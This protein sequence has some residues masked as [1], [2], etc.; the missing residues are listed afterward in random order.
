MTEG[1]ENGEHDAML[2]AIAAG[3]LDALERLYR[4]LRIGVFAAAVAVVRDRALAEDVLQDTFVRVLEKAS[5]Y[6]PGTRARAW[7][8]AIAR[9]LAIDA[10]RRRREP[11]R[12]EPPVESWGDPLGGL[13]VTRALLALE[14]VEREIVAL[15]A[16]GGLTHAEIAVQLAM[17]A[18]TVRWKYRAALDRLA[19][20]FSEA[21]DA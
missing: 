1:S 8:L 14:P 7:V 13:V 18:G 15:H 6:R 16:L 21:V 20:L 12:R 4:E 11:A 2:G 5:T 9:N 19:P 3:D 10:L 17:P